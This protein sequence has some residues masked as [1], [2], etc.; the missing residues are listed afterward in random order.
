MPFT[1]F[2]HLKTPKDA[3]GF[4]KEHNAAIDGEGDNWN[5]SYIFSGGLFRKDKKIAINYD[6][7]WCSPP[8]WPKQIAGMQNYV[9]QWK[10]GDAVREKLTLLIRR[11]AFCLGMANEPE[12]TKGNDPRLEIMHA[13]AEYMDGLFFT[14][15]ALLDSQ[16]RPFVSADGESDP[17]AVLPEVPEIKVEIPDGVLESIVL[18]PSPKA[19]DGAEE[20]KPDPPTAHRVAKRLYSMTAI[21]A[22]GLLDMNLAMGNRPAHSLEELQGWLEPLDVADEIEPYENRILNTTA[23]ELGRQDAINS[24]WTLEGIGVLAWALGL[25]QLPKYDEL[26]NTD[27]LLEHLSFLDSD[28]CRRNLDEASLRTA[29]ELGSYNNQIFALNWRMV[30][31]RVRPQATDYA[32]VVIAGGLFDLSWATLKNGDLSL[33]GKPIAEA[34]SELIKTMN[35]LAVERHKASNW[36]LGYDRLYSRISTD[37]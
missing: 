34:D 26:V 30:D 5:A 27:H 33:Q 9:L 36:L 16:F 32:N 20:D 15:G 23:G 10:M 8:N 28:A 11:F 12:I 4:L 2:C 17:T 37:T 31:F 1:L 22:R 13:L 14:P 3:L 7:D 21:A 6:R 18:S 25:Y 35:S 24:V 19:E 29:E